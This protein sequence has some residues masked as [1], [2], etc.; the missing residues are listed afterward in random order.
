M[1]AIGIC[2][3]LCGAGRKFLNRPSSVYTAGEAFEFITAVNPYAFLELA[4]QKKP[5]LV[6]LDI[7]MEGP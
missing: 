3:D 5:A 7:D 4:T 2:D 1:L 6:F